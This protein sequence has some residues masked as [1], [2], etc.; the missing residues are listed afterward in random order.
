MVRNR[1]LNLIISSVLGP[2]LFLI[3]VADIDNEVKHDC[4]FDLLP[5]ILE[6]CTVLSPYETFQTFKLMLSVIFLYCACSVV[7][8]PFC[9]YRPHEVYCVKIHFSRCVENVSKMKRKS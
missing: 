2:L 4:V 6:Q 1:L 7:A 9:L 8:I 3:L 5:M